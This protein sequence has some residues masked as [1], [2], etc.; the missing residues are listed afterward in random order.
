MEIIDRRHEALGGQSNDRPLSA[1]T[2]IV[3]HYTAVARK[4]K[5]FITNHEAYWRDTNGWDRGGYHFYI[6]ADG[7]IYQNYNYERM[8]WGVAY[9]NDYTVHITCEAGNGNDYSQAQIAARDWLTRKIMSDLNISASNVKGH[10]EV[11]N[12]SACPGYT[13]T[14]MDAYRRSLADGKPVGSAPTTATNK[15]DGITNRYSEH[16][17]FYPNDTIIVRD[18]PSTSGKHIATYKEG[19]QVAYHTVHVGNGYVWLEYARNNGGSGFIPCRECSN[20][21]IGDLWGGIDDPQPRDNRKN[22]IGITKIY[23]EIGTFYPND[24]IIVRDKP[25]TSGKIVTHYYAGENVTYHTVHVGNGYVWLEY[26]RHSGQKGFIP[27]R[28]YANGKPGALW[29]TIE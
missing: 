27:C 6:D 12:N 13:R 24:T 19:E 16:G 5:R 23:A 22:I 9:S 10:Y 26:L 14:Q 1:I 15:T 21:E 2:T 8:T 25:S 18:Q 3:W 7:I 4:L 28:E 29:G 11:Y 17:I 20:G